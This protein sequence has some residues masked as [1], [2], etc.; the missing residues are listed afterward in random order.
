MKLKIHKTIYNYE[1]NNCKNCGQVFSGKVCN[2]CGEKV[3]HEKQL[4]A[5]HY[6]HEV[7]DFFYHFEN[8]VLKT[9][10]L[11]ILKPGFITAENLRGV[12][13]PY[14][15][16]VQLYLVVAVLFYV[17]VSK[18]RVTDYIPQFGDHK[19]YFVSDYHLLKW[20][21][22]LDNW[23]VNRI[24]TM[25]AKKG[26][27]IQQSFAKQDGPQSAGQEAMNLYGKNKADSLLIPAG[28]TE[29]YLYQQMRLYRWSMF[30]A[31]I[32]TY[33]KTFIF[34]LLP[35]F[36]GFF[37][38]LFFKKIK[39]YGAAL[40]LSTHFMVYNLCAYTIYAIVNE[41][42]Y[43]L[44]KDL[45]GWMFKPFDWL[46]Y[47]KYLEP[48][49]TFILGEP[50]EMIHIIF[51]MPWLFLAFK[52]LYSA[53]WWKNLLISYLC[54]KVFFFLIFGVLKKL[55]IVFTIWTMHA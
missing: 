18:V 34:I 29:V 42:P 27:E 26:N 40:I 16:P 50:F 28:K 2:N 12:R 51:W 44:H 33:A 55:L 38:L 49:S 19:Y 5:G 43:Q 20:A 45:G 53:A 25:W 30:Q 37:F 48:V 54:C 47:N 31:K 3:F 52:R 23:I 36:A 21:S 6:L 8:K 15:K 10:K 22:P 11:N 9:I 7:I 35:V 46:L 24:D 39:Y 41:W 4:S 14:A 1:S 13:V 32:G 17:V